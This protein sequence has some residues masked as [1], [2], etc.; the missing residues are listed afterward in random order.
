MILRFTKRKR[1]SL[2]FKEKSNRFFLV[3]AEAVRVFYGDHE[4]T[5]AVPFLAQGAEAGKGSLQPFCNLTEEIFAPQIQRGRITDKGT[6][7]LPCLSV[8]NG[9]KAVA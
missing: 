5:A 6:D 1:P 9:G 8:I 7:V 4:N 2:R 3:L